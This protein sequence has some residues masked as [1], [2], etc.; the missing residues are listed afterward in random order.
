M[1]MK[2]SISIILILFSFSNNSYCQKD[3]D[4]IKSSLLI[5]GKVLGGFFLEDV[6]ILNATL[7]FEYQF[8]KNLSV[9]ADFVHVNEIFEKEDH[10]D[11]TNYD[12]YN[13]YAQK[14]PRTCL[15]TDIR[16][17]PFRKKFHESG[18]QP[19][20]CLFSKIGNIITWNVDGYKFS[21]DEVVRRR[22]TFYD[23]GI[24]AGIHFGTNRFGLD[25]NIGYC[26]RTQKENVEY[27]V[28]GGPNR[29]VNNH[30]FTKD[31]LA[32]RLNLY[33]NLFRK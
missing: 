4:S 13:E 7:G 26:Q 19:Y 28:D 16:F 15:L 12:V 6:W 10:Y 17:Y 11:S 23:L 8:L 9:G 5:R 14:N 29:F 31:K 33:Y 20:L 18:I 22:G 27:Y 24:T 30:V 21:N 25:F 32:G 1:A 2:I 3:D